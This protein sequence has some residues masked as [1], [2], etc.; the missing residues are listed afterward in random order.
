M[1]A[2]AVL[3]TL[4]VA[5]GI[6]MAG[7][8]LLMRF[9]RRTSDLAALLDLP[10][11][12]R[13]VAVSYVTERTPPPLLQ[14]AV[15]FTGTLLAQVDTKNRLLAKLEKAR[16]PVR[17]AEYA[18]TAVIMTAVTAL[19]IAAITERWIFGIAAGAAVPFVAIAY[20]NFRIARRKRAIEEQLPEA[21][22]IIASSMSAGH[23]FLRSIQMMCEESEPPLA[24]EFARVVHETRLGDPLVD[25]LE[26]MAHRLEISDLVWVVQA[27][28]IQQTVGGKL[29]D[30][31]HSLAEFI[32][33]R[34]EIRREIDV[35][36]A[37]GRISAWVLGAMPVALTLFIQVSSPGYLDPMF[38]GWGP[39]VMIMA[40]V[41][42]VFGFLIIRRMV[43]IEV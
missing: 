17:P 19:F 15:G 21:L 41:S 5:G 33:A 30:L 31:L 36:T 22:S 28:R 14:G 12:E 26:R 32:R 38:R 11:G 13:D 3:A 7:A 1:S 9:R 29:S 40:A 6:A 24:E 43:K 34:E 39:V 4:F 2:T 27:I 10:Y 35:L 23:T 42:V 20:L 18:L 8:G 37:E 16:L 25:S